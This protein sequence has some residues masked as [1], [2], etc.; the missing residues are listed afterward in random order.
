MDEED[1]RPMIVD[2]M[3]NNL[4]YTVAHA[5]FG[6]PAFFNVRGAGGAVVIT[7]NTRHK[8][9]ADLFDKIQLPEENPEAPPLEVATLK[10]DLE[11]AN[12]ALLLMLMAWARLEDE[13]MGQERTRMEDLRQDWGR[14]AR[15]FLNF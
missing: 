10:A 2:I 15:D 4:K 9:Y 11:K 1:V 8:A 14:V 3:E 5:P 13:S 7:I 6:G 12:S